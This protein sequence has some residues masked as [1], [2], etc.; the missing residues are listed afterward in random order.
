MVDE[1]LARDT[2][3]GGVAWYLPDRLG[4][5]CD[6]IDNWGTVLDHIAYDAYGNI[7]SQS[8]ASAGY[9][10]GTPGC[11]RMGQR[12]CISIWPGGTTRGAGGSLALIRRTSRPGT[13]IST[14]TSLMGRRT[15]SIQ[16]VWA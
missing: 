7:L 4:T 14:D 8:N 1:V 6:I 13:L 11:R 16:A 3:S 10:S 12:A 9:R 5:V 15:T 2:P